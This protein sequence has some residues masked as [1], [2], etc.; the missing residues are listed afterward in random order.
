MRIDTTILKRAGITVRPDELERLVND[1]LLQWL[2]PFSPPD[3]RFALPAATQQALHAVGVSAADL[4][5][6]RPDEPRPDLQA[7]A[8]HAGLAAA[9]LTVSQAAARL[10]VDPSRIRQRLAA[11]TLFGIR[12]EGSWRL[13]LFQFTDDGRS[14]VTSF[15][16][17]APRLAD[18]HPLDVATWFTTPHG[19]LVLGV[20]GDEE[21]AVSPREWLLG[22]GD[23]SALLPLVDELR[24]YA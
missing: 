12:V 24:G 8:E 3:A 20:A 16:T 5:P 22:G 21:I 14:V 15:G 7:A 1:A 6:L 18:L 11:R 17:I 10:G 13:P 4:A 23:A 19:D 9:A 2:P